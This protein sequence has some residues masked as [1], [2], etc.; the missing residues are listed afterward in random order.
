MKALCSNSS[1]LKDKQPGID[2]SN[3]VFAMSAE[4][5]FS[6]KHLIMA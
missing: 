1:E 6:L 5:D 3:D 4:P 2:L